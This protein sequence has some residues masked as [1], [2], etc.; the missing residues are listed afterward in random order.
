[1]ALRNQ[2]RGHRADHLTDDS[3]LLAAALLPGVPADLSREI[4]GRAPGNELA[5]GKFAS[6]ES[7]A[8]LAANTFGPFLLRP[9]DLPPLPGTGAWGWPASAVRLEALLRFPWWGGRHPA[10]TPWSIPGA[11]PIAVKSKRHERF[12]TK[13]PGVAIS[14]A[15]WRP[16]WGDAM[17]GCQRVRDALRGRGRY[18]RLDAAQLVKHA[19]GPRTAVHREPRLAGRRLVLLYLHAEP[20]RGPASVWFRGSR[21][22]R[23]GPRSERSPR[24]WPATRSRFAPARTANFW[25]PGPPAAVWVVALRASVPN[26]CCVFEAGT[27]HGRQTGPPEKGVH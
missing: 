27:G 20:E 16:A 10:S 3:E 12:R 15:Y 6:P 9:A 21:L 18:V 8:E 7:S 2:A 13:P 24:R 17:T 22:T 11:A 5:S 1:M 19:L 14:D 25:P 4:Y 23:I 26:G